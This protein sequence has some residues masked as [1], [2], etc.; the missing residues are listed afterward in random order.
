MVTKEIFDRICAETP[1][2]EPAFL[3]H[4]DTTVRFLESKYGKKFVYTT[5]Y[6]KPYSV[7]DDIPVYDEYF[8]A[9]VDNIL[10]LLTKDTDRRTDAIAEADYA[11]KTIWGARVH[12]KRFM[13]V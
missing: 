13:G 7:N 10:F 3:R 5:A 12:G 4:L 8:P 2:G 11:Y 6:Q 9:V 1:C